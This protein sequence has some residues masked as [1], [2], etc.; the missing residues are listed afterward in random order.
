QLLS[1]LGRISIAGAE[2]IGHEDH[3]IRSSNSPGLPDCVSAD[4][5]PVRLHEDRSA[6]LLRVA[7]TDDYSFEVSAIDLIRHLHLR[8]LPHPFAAP[9]DHHCCIRASALLASEP[10][11]PPGGV[12]D[13]TKRVDC[14]PWLNPLWSADK[15]FRSGGTRSMSIPCKFERSVLS[16][17]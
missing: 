17:E 9:R 6:L 11:G 8:H 2:H 12:S 7:V 13:T 15:V 16:F 1:R 14:R 10:S 4:A 3:V 5:L